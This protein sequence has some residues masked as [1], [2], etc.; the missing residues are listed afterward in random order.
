MVISL[1]LRKLIEKLAFLATE[2][3][4]LNYCLKQTQAEMFLELIANYLHHPIGCFF[5]WV[6]EINLTIQS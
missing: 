4:L 5:I 1:P 2:K 3:I 6:L